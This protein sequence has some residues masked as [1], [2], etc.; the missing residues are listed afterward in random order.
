MADRV[1]DLNLAYMFSW[2][3]TDSSKGAH[4]IES[5]LKVHRQ[6]IVPGFLI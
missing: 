2:I 6:A 5:L 3:A 4:D 1:P